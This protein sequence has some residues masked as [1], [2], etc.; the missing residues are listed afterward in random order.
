M[1]E[2]HENSPV[3][4]LAAMQAQLDRI[5]AGLAAQAAQ[6]R[7]ILRTQRLRLLLTCLFALGLCVVAALLWQRVDAAATG[8]AQASREV[9]QLAG[10]VQSELDTLDPDALQQVITA[11]PEI[12]AKLK[13]LDVEA[14]NEALRLMPQLVTTVNDLQSRIQ[15]IQDWFS[16]LGGVFGR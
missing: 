15:S 10:R 6:S 5:E 14:L 1:P 7:S 13:E 2:I 4:N 9:E 3:P 16:N 11:L 12:T 8:I